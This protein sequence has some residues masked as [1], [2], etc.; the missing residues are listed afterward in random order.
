[1]PRPSMPSLARRRSKPCRRIARMGSPPIAWPGR[2]ALDAGLRLQRTAPAR[3]TPVKLRPASP[4]P[5]RGARSGARSGGGP[6]PGPRARAPGPGPPGGWGRARWRARP[7]ARRGPPREGP[8]REPV[9]GPGPGPRAGEITAYMS[10]PIPQPPPPKSPNLA[11]DGPGLP[12]GKVRLI[13]GIRSHVVSAKFVVTGPMFCQFS[14]WQCM[15]ELPQA[16]G[17]GPG[18]RGRAR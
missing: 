18:P 10:H 17:P 15:I 16:R 1:M 8:A 5:G 3:G 7:G 11:P 12:P 4:G 13:E 14:V 9:R 6:G 2:H